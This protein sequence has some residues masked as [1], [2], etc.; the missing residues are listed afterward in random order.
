MYINYINTSSRL[1]SWCPKNQNES[2]K[3]TKRVSEVDLTQKSLH[4]PKPTNLWV[5]LWI[6]SKLP[7]LTWSDAHN[8][9]RLISYRKGHQR[10]LSWELDTNITNISCR[11]MEAK[12]HSTDLEKMVLVLYMAV[13]MRTLTKNEYQTG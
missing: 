5:W 1:A 10:K 8:A 13:A 11:N 12:Q 6:G 9:V 2:D 7:P 3:F 4:Q